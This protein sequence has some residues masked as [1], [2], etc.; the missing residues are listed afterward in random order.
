MATNVGERGIK[1]AVGGSF[2]ATVAVE[3]LR[4][5]GVAGLFVGSRVASPFSNSSGSEAETSCLAKIRSVWL[6]W[7]T[8][9]VVKLSKGC[10]SKPE[11]EFLSEPSH[12]LAAGVTE[13]AKQ[14]REM[15]LPARNRRSKRRN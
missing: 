1:V 9:E 7:E 4:G 15:M 8:S 2:G 11:T 14:T 12:A 6:V 10:F 5:N 3:L 13:K